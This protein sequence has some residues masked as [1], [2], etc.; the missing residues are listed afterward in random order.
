MS[1]SHH[2]EHIEHLGI[3]VK[4]VSA[5]EARY[6]AML[7]VAPYKREEVISEGVTTVFF[8]IGPNKI[9]LLKATR[10]DSPIATFIERRGE[11]LHHVAYKVADI[12]A[13]MARLKQE[14]FL[15]L[16]EEPKQGADNMLVAFVHPRTAGGVLIELCQTQEA[17]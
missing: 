3:A 13:E 16:S 7:G 9:E 14:G 8:Q 2:F 1:Q 11:G 6:T 10:P 17:K 4:D 12:R 5:A 15:L